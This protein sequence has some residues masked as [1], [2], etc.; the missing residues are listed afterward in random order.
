MHIKR[1]NGSLIVD[2]A[3]CMPIFIIGICML[4]FLIAQAGIEETT[5]YALT[6]SARSCART[7]AVAS[8]EEIKIPAAA[9]TYKVQW[10]SILLSEWGG[11]HPDAKITELSFENN[12]ILPEGNISIDHVVYASGEV[13]TFLPFPEY[14]TLDPASQKKVVFRPFVGESVQNT[15]GD[16]TGVYIFPKR[17]ERYHSASCYILRDGNIEVLLTSKLRE[18]KNPCKSCSPE[19]LPNGAKVYMFSVKSDVYHK[20]SCPTITKRYI[21]IPKGEAI[22]QGYTPCRICGGGN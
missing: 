16:M 15:A 1:K 14:F 21:C 7:Y 9:A 13:L 19:K 22:S 17:G 18:E 4:L 2:A 6:Q 10:E 5:Q 8:D 11:E 12:T 20:K 3:C